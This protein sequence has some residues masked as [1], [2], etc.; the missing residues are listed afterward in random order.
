MPSKARS[1]REASARVVITSL[2]THK[3]EI[4]E[5]LAAFLRPYAKRGEALPEVGR[6]SSSWRA[7]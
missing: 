2:T 5:G 1:D 4:E 6:S 7:L 3:A